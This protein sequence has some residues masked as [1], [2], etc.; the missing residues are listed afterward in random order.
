MDGVKTRLAIYDMDKT[1]TRRPTYTPFLLHAARTRG[2]WR[3]FLL[4]LVAFTLALYAVR[5]IDRAKLK[6]LNHALLI[7]RA[8]P[9]AE[10]AKLAESFAA[11]TLAKNILPKAQ[12]RVDADKAEGYRLVLA[13]ASYAFYAGAIARALGF[14][15]TIGTMTRTDT[16]GAL[17][18]RIDEQNCYGTA[19]LEMVEAWMTRQGLRRE[20]CHIRFYSDHVSDAPCL[21]W[22]DEGFATN[23]HAPLVALA[24]QRGWTVFDW[25]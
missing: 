16:A 7:G 4:P 25:R 1:V 14:D 19:K 17:L 18:A 2:I 20:D 12:A 24:A 8:L 6:E 5:L 9:P 13:T 3:L 22:A 23:A 15:D 21:N 11:E 10:A